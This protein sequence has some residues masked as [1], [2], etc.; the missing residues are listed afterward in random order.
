M[1]TQ[2]TTKLLRQLIWDYNIPANEIEDVL[3]GK[4]LR[5]G[6]YT[7]EQLFIKIL[8]TYPWYTVLQ[9]L[10]PEE[11]LK[12]LTPEVI[13]KLRTPSLRKKYDFVRSRLQDVIPFS[14]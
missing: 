13:R 9:I 14:G 7:R 4:K 12:L 3:S 10:T 8:E 11:I 1:E 2:S 6:H 5:A